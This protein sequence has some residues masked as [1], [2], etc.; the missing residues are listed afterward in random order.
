VFGVALGQ[1][2]PFDEIIVVM[3]LPMMIRRNICRLLHR[4]SL[5]SGSSFR[6][7]GW[8]RCGTGYRIRAARSSHLST[9]DSDDFFWNPQKNEQ[10]GGNLP[11]FGRTSGNCVLRRTEVTVDGESLCAVSAL[12]QIHEGAIFLAPFVPSRIHPARLHVLE[13][14]TSQPGLR[15]KHHPPQ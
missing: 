3:M 8:G 15:S 10:D 11:R 6:P 13:A 9:L 12:R 7:A 14:C 5:G 4:G 1:S 2:L